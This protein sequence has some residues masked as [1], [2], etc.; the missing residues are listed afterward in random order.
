MIV[1]LL[2][3]FMKT[4]KNKIAAAGQKKLLPSWGLKQIITS[5]MLQQYYITWYDITIGLWF[6]YVY[7]HWDNILRKQIQNQLKG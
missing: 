3:F 7:M 4:K 6:V 1:E 2:F 5:H